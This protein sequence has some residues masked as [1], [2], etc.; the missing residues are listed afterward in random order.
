MHTQYSPPSLSLSS[1]A[2]AVVHITVNGFGGG[3]GDGDISPLQFPNSAHL[4]RRQLLPEQQVKPRPDVKVSLSVD[5]EKGN[6]AISG[7]T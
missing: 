1:A 3:G 5:G 4:Q 6:R 2:S 7:T